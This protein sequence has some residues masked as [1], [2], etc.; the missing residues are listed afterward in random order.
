M[1]IIPSEIIEHNTYILHH[2]TNII[3]HITPHLNTTFH[4]TI[5]QRHPSTYHIDTVFITPYTNTI[6]HHVI[7]Y[8][9]HSTSHTDPIF[10][11]T[12]HTSPYS[13]QSTSSSSYS[14]PISLVLRAILVQAHAAIIFT[15]ITIVIIKLKCNQQV[16][17]QQTSLSLM[18]PSSKIEMKS[19][20]IQATLVTFNQVT[21][22]TK[23]Y[24]TINKQH[25]SLSLIFI[26]HTEGH[27]TTYLV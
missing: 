19:Q 27:K 24:Q 15:H 11:P 4:Q 5:L 17:N 8:Q 16:N 23:L 14:H 1:S 9:L 3:L 18:L 12:H 20:F 13:Q 6:I 26:H 2:L 10:T 25:P 7:P 22:V 21:I